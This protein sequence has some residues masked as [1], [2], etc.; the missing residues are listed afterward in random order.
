MPKEIDRQLLLGI[1]KVVKKEL[2]PWRESIEYYTIE[3]FVGCVLAE[4][5]IK[6]IITAWEESVL[7]QK[8]EE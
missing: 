6:G 2:A 4:L 8:L 7:R 3:T 1:A 5:R